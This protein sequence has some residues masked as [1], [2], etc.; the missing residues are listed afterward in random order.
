M[1]ILLFTSQINA[2]NYARAFAGIDQ[3]FVVV[4]LV[5][6]QERKH[7]E[8]LLA[9]FDLAPRP[10]VTLSPIFLESPNEKFRNFLNPRNLF[11][12]FGA[13]LRT[14]RKHRPDAVIGMYI[15]HTYP[16]VLLRRFVGFTLFVIV[17]GGDLEQHEGFMWRS[18]R[19]IV[20]YNSQLIFAVGYR[21]KA[22]IERETGSRVLVIPT[23]ADPDFYRPIRDTNLRRKYGLSRNDFVVLTLSR[24]VEAKCIDDVINAV[25]QLSNKHMNVKMII[26]GD[27]PDEERLTHMRDALRLEESIFFTGWIGD[28]TKRDLFNIAD[29]YVIASITRECH[30][31]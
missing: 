30:F 4:I 6:K 21:L 31:P 16:L 1:R 19:R 13:I 20:Y 10:N 24:L 18:I 8:E 17:S 12:D 15:I 23:S 25:K 2:L 3:Q 26:A 11:H 27:G 5:P 29:V 22:E 28:A 7:Y 9:Q 14:L